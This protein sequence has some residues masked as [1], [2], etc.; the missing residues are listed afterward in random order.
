MKELNVVIPVY[1]EQDAVI[2]LLE[3]WTQLLD[4]LQIDYIINIYNDG[5]TDNTAL[6]LKEFTHGRV[7]AHNRKNSGHGPT[8]L[9]GY[10]ENTAEWILQIDSDREI[11]HTHFK[12][13]WHKRRNYDFLIGT[14]I[15]RKS[16]LPRLILSVISRY[17]VLLLFG[18]GIYD[19]NCP[20][21]LM[22]SEKIQK[23]IQKIPPKTF[24]PNVIISGIAVSKKLC[25][26][27]IP[28]KFSF[29]KTGEVSIKKWKLLRAAF[30]SFIQLI[31]CRLQ[32]F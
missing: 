21:R 22:R 24:A 28:V 9:K 5:S 11:S 26:C 2:T 18:S 3:E 14:R 8:I 15:H 19:V 20:Y 7:I 12:T 6:F 31:T 30:I 4:A 16:P 17:A 13:F 29:R 1:N 10:C 32:F 27:E 23:Y 25:I